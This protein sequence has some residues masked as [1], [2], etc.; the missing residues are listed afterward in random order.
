MQ[1]ISEQI[2]E[3]NPE[4]ETWKILMDY[5]FAT[6]FHCC[7]VVNGTIYFIGGMENS[8]SKIHVIIVQTTPP[9]MLLEYLRKQQ[10]YDVI[11]D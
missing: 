9:K 10:L 3:F 2:Y 1:T 6:Y 5:P 4:K 11:I 7:Q 8:L